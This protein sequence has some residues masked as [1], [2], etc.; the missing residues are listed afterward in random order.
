MSAVDAELV[1]QVRSE[2]AVRAQPPTATAVAQVLR[3]RNRLVGGNSVLSI[4]ENLKQ[5]HGFG[6]LSSLVET[7]GVTDVLVNG[8][9]H[10]YIDRGFG[11]ERTAVKFES[12]KHLRRFA[13]RLAASAG[14]RLDDASPFVDARLPE[15][16]RLHA[17]LAPIVQPGTAI[18]LRVMAKQVL[19]IANLQ[20]LG[21]FDSDL[22][23]M[24]RAVMQSR[25]AFVIS[26][27][28]GAGKTTLL[29]ALLSDVQSDQRLVIV[30]DSAE[31][32]PQHPHFLSLESRPSN[33]EGAGLITMRD[34]VRQALRMRPDRLVIGEVRGA[35]IV[36]MLA[37][38]NTGH[39]GGCGTVHANSS[40]DVPAR[41]EALGVAAG[42]SREAVHSQLA[43]ALD[44]VIH[45]ER[46]A[47]GKRRLKE[48]SLVEVNDGGKVVVVPAVISNHKTTIFT[49]RSDDLIDQLGLA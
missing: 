24:L 30:E 28:T 11:L 35:E 8:P 15:G 16:V 41:F 4:V 17:V 36:E 19:T 27:G 20:E 5:D 3:D 23:Q 42:L 32:T 22:A 6:V 49:E 13:Q 14:R 33:I 9:N 46:D 7:P 1:E 45:V 37:A 21:M 44:L 34:L 39:E 26:G 48:I 18:S 43:A 2:L 29:S 25:L 38:L 47:D 10:V 40:Q 12:E 31:L